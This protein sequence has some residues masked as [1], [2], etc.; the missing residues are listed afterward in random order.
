LNLN[1]SEKE[2]YTRQMIISDWGESGQQKIKN[3][4]VFIAGAGGL[5]SPV[6][7]YLAAAGVGTLRICDCGEPELS[8]L[9]RQILHSE[10]DIGINKAISAE[11]SIKL[12]NS[13][14]RV[15]PITNRITEETVEGIVG[16]ADI[17]VDCLDNFEARHILNEF[18]VK[19]TLPFIHAGIHG[20][21][22]QV[23]F[24]H[25]PETPCLR[26]VFPGVVPKQVFPV[27]GVT[28]GIIGTIE[29]AEVL[30]WIVGIGDNLKNQLL[31]WEGD[32][33][34][35]QKIAIKKDPD[36]PVCGKL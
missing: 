35:F 36:C 29:S 16:D 18:A 14:V 15:E 11:A 10:S 21:S 27:V 23:T 4:T 28:P 17:I 8:N 20:L 26:C 5:G 34:D 13:N 12:L 33:M 22:G 19:K 31:I 3:S 24:I 1:S 7:V 30:K 2:R 25:T 9:N 32:T 6:S